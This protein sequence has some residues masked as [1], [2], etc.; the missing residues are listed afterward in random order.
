MKI[1]KKFNFSQLF[2][3]LTGTIIIYIGGAWGVY[4]QFVM[5]NNGIYNYLDFVLYAIGLFFILYFTKI[6][7]KNAKKESS[8]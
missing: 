2:R 8:K 6:E 3:L 4:S 7:V 5:K 1:K